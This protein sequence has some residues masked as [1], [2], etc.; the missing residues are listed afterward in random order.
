M[1]IETK[2]L[3]KL[4]LAIQMCE[5]AQRFLEHPGGDGKLDKQAVLHNIKSLLGVLKEV[6][7]HK[8]VDQ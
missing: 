5:R 7:E 4:E 3:T 6:N 8:E 1:M 2:R